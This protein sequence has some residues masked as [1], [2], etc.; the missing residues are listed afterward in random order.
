MARL[1]ALAREHEVQT[2]GVPAFL[3]ADHLVLGFDGPECLEALLVPTAARDPTIQLPL[4]GPLDPSALGLPLFTIVL[5]LVDGFNPCATWVLLFVL[6]LLVHL[7]SRA[8][9]LAVG[10]TFVLVS[11]L[12][13][14]AFMEAWLCFYLL[15]GVSRAVQVLLGLLAVAVGVVHIKEFV[16]LGAGPSLSIPAAAKPGIVKRARAIL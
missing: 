9:M 4:V 1:Q 10:G 3:V 8:R 15:V 5:G 2:L 6:S 14:F 13:Y 11:G 12:A 7:E 16:A